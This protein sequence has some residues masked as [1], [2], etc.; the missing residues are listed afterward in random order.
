MICDDDDFSVLWYGGLGFVHDFYIIS[1]FT[2]CGS[3]SLRQHC[4]VGIFFHLNL[5]INFYD[6]EKQHACKIALSSPLVDHPGGRQ[7]SGKDFS[8]GSV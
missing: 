5:E 1:L 2:F 4:K 7:R 6:F 8:T 3:R